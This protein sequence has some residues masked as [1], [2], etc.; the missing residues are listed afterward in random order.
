MKSLLS[1]T[2]FKKIF[3][4]G[5]GCLLISLWT[6]TVINIR[7]FKQGYLES[8]ELNAKAIASRSEE[9]ILSAMDWEGDFKEVANQTTPN[10]SRL[11]L[12]REF[13]DLLN[14]LGIIDTFGRILAHAN[15]E[16]IGNALPQKVVHQLS[17]K[18]NPV[19]IKR[20]NSYDIFVPIV[21]NKKLYGFT[22]VGFAPWVIDN[23][24]QDAIRH[25]V[26]ITLVSVI[27]AGISFAFSIA[28]FITHPL[29]NIV[30]KIRY[31]TRSGDFFTQIET[32][33]I[34][35][36]RNLIQITDKDVKSG[37][38]EPDKKEKIR[39]KDEIGILTQS[40]NE[41]VL[42]IRQTITERKRAEAEVLK[43][44]QLNEKIIN[45]SPIGL[46]IYDH[47]GQ[48]IAANTAIAEMVAA[49]PEQV[50]AQ[51]YNHIDSWKKSGLLDVANKSIRLQRKERHD[52][53]VVTT[54]GKHAFYDCLF[55]PFK[56]RGEQHLLLMVDDVSERKQAEAEL[57]R[58][59]STLEEMVIERTR[60]L[61]DVQAELLRKNR[62][63]TLGQLTATVSHE[64]RNPLGSMRPSLYIIRKRM[65]DKDPRLTQALERIDRNI[66]RCDHIID[67]LLDF[68][69][70]QELEL[71]PSVLDEWLGEILNELAVPKG[72]TVVRELGLF[73]L[74]MM[75]DYNRLRRA[76]INVYD[77]ACQAMLEETKSGNGKALTLTVAT[78]Q[79]DDR[80]EIEFADTGP[81]IAPDVLERIFEP[82]FSTKNFGVGLG[83]PT[84]KQ[85]MEQHGGGIHVTSQ[86]GGG[87][88]VLLWLPRI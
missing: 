41:M 79:K 52:F 80:I 10:L 48:C 49:A 7:T 43:A 1:P 11:L 82:L 17:N 64:L 2:L 38:G 9:I 8:Y 88:Q 78:R 83:L 37:K 23:K 62:L 5:M 86:E 40:F 13:K 87:T 31:I 16:L 69:R 54:F 19:T 60:D 85:I 51:N 65:S 73:S 67:E 61:Q 74:E 71:L 18:I 26:I 29:K 75:L 27:L 45:E 63:A 70:I 4:I 36:T 68:T 39:S 76:V 66:T 34:N 33:S 35:E 30:G 53:G 50:L 22:V 47:T 12:H 57:D 81:G 15:P 42:S 21:H 72:I 3:M 46:S 59:R 77:N 24:I 25:S 44:S 58:Y 84:V 14:Q 32:K 28:I 56:L 6:V 55:V 20:N